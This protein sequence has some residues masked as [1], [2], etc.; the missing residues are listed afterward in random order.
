MIGAGI[1]CCNQEPSNRMLRKSLYMFFYMSVDV[2]GISYDHISHWSM[3]RL[4]SFSVI[5]MYSFSHVFVT[6]TMHYL[7]YACTM[8]MYIHV[9]TC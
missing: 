5:F 2:N 7:W 4:V 3:C 1:L 9:C 8:Y 6:A